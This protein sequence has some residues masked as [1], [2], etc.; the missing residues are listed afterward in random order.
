M[1]EKY[2]LQD[3]KGV[4]I[5]NTTWQGNHAI[6]K[7]LQP[8]TQYKNWQVKRLSDGALSKVGDLDFTT[9]DND[10]LEF[11]ATDIQ[12]D[13]LLTNV[14]EV[15]VLTI[16]PSPEDAKNFDIQPL[17]GDGVSEFISV[18][19]T[20]PKTMSVKYLKKN[21]SANT[22][23]LSLIDKNNEDITS[24]AT[25]EQFVP[26]DKIV[27]TADDADYT[28]GDPNGIEIST[29][30]STVDKSKDNWSDSVSPTNIRHYLTKV[31]LSDSQN[32][33][34]AT[35]D[36]MA[37]TITPTH[38][39]TISVNVGLSDIAMGDEASDG[40]DHTSNTL[41]ATITDKE[42]DGKAGFHVAFSKKE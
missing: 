18:E 10:T 3:E 13:G 12:N 35:G 32:G 40:K 26:L 34:E 2:V 37:Q 36:D 31:I 27:I 25:L 5:E 15:L 41:L 20:S 22:L 1:S 9:L 8:N 16:S 23:D 28:V 21:L 17:L 11:I 14:D 7:G 24:D 4:Q 33:G 6:V 42:I 30:G 38:A 39:G 19:V 29:I